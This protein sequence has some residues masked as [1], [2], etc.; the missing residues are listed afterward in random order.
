MNQIEVKTTFV[1]NPNALEVFADSVRIVSV[2]DGVMRIELCTTKTDGKGHNSR[3]CGVDPSRSG[4]LAWCSDAASDRAGKARTG[5]TH[6]RSDS[7]SSALI[8]P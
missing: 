2:S 8:D 1:D 6:D 3:S 4:Q 7:F 5:E